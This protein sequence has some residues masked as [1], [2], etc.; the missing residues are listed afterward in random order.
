MCCSYEIVVQLHCAVCRCAALVLRGVLALPE[1]LSGGSQTRAAVIRVS[2]AT[3]WSL[4]VSHAVCQA[5]DQIHVELGRLGILL[6]R[7]KN[8][9]TYET[10]KASTAY[11]SESV[12]VS[13]PL[14][15]LEYR[16]QLALSVCALHRQLMLCMRTVSAI[17]GSEM[18]RIHGHACTRTSTARTQVRFAVHC[19]PRHDSMCS[20]ARSVVLLLPRLTVEFDDSPRLDALFLSCLGFGERLHCGL[21]VRLAIGRTRHAAHVFD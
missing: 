12:S 20:L 18:S 5:T 11:A 14:R 6:V 10:K 1:E 21:V 15:S 2:H 13:A 17:E 19:T 16:A 8:Q 7:V 9:I 4:S 3:A